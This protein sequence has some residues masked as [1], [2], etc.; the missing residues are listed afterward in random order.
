VMHAMANSAARGLYGIGN[1][2]P[3]GLAVTP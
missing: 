2:V 3:G 1:D